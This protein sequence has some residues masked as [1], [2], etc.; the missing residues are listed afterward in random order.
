MAANLSGMFTQLNNAIAGN[1]LAKGG[2][3][4]G[5]LDM[6]SMGL[7]GGLG[8][9]LGQ[10]PYSFMS[11]GG[12]E[13]QAKKDMA[14]LDLGTLQGMTDA[15][16]IYGKLGDTQGQLGMSQMAETKRLSDIALQRQQASRENL[17]KRAR[18]VGLDD[19]ADNILAGEPDTKE[20]AKVI[21]DE[22]LLK[23]AALRSG[24]ARRGI[25]KQFGIDEKE[26][27]ASNLARAT[28]E[29]FTDYVRGREADVKAYQDSLGKLVS[30]PTSKNGQ[31]KDPTDGSWKFPSEAGLSPAP[32]VQKVINVSSKFKVSMAE[33]GVAKFEE[34]HE[35]AN[36]AQLQLDNI[37][38]S[39]DYL[40]DMPTGIGAPIEAFVGKVADYFGM[41]RPEVANY[42]VFLAEAGKRVAEQIKA[43]GSGTGLSDADREY[44]KLIAAANPSLK[45]A[46]LRRLLEIQK[47]T[48]TQ[49]VEIFK[50]TKI[51]IRK[52]MGGEGYVV[53]M[54][55]LRRPSDNAALN[56]PP[57]NPTFNPDTG[58]IE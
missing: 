36:N 11:Q 23:L 35:K 24:P 6:A 1:P 18:A 27:T 51:K 9:A 43:F 32:Q 21:R 56:P 40:E 33:A 7:G 29:V 55:S 38:R 52:E 54:F 42:E 50:D 10:D 3:G 39:L 58:K 46:S 16:S 37:E 15:G 47:E 5:M 41:D 8:T 14:G 25:A 45:A 12:K 20:A 17:A 4:K 30:V 49:T 44:A 22:E 31:I 53:D 57:K 26:F 34:L 19:M 13:I 28:P 48:A 2:S